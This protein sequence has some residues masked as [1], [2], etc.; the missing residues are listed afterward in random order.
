MEITKE[1]LHEIFDYKDGNLIWKCNRGSN[2]TKGKVAGYIKGKNDLRNDG[3]VVI[4]LKSKNYK[5]HRLIW[6]YFNDDI[7]SGLQI[8]H[9]NGIRHD[10]RIENLR[11]VTNQEN[12]FNRKNKGY[13][14]SKKEKKYIATITINRNKIRLGAFNTPEEAQEKY[15]RAKDEYHVIK[16]RL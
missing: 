2:K 8:D 7:P 4:S 5:A 1:Y 9:I 13:S 6:H 12:Q 11:L 14:Y 16:N 10:N 15:L 3:Y